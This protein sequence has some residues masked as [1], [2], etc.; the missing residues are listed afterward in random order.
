MPVCDR[1]MRTTCTC[2]CDSKLENLHW[3]SFPKVWSTCTIQVGYRSTPACGELNAC[4]MSLWDFVAVKGSCHGS[5]WPGRVIIT[6]STTGLLH[7]IWRWA[8]CVVVLLLSHL[9]IHT[10]RGTATIMLHVQLNM[11]IE[12]Y[13]INTMHFSVRWLLGLNWYIVQAQ[14][15]TH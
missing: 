10:D 11:V 7:L 8:H 4:T 14:N 13:N 2:R 9:Q 5:R 3:D 15:I 6:S 12:L 1:L